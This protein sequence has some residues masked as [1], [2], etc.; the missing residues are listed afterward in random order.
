MYELWEDSLLPIAHG[1]ERGVI[2]FGSANILSWPTYPQ[3]QLAHTHP[4]EPQM[5]LPARPL[6]QEGLLL[7]IPMQVS[8]P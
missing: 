6:S 1:I 3:T 2:D 5:P 8:E 4:S 7:P